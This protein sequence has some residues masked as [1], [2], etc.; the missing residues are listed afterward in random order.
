[1]KKS[2]GEGAKSNALTQVWSRNLGLQ[3]LDLF[4]QQGDVLQQIFVLQQQLM[5]P[6]LSLQTSR[7][8]GTQLVLQEVDLHRRMFKGSF[9]LTS[10]DIMTVFLTN[11]FFF[12][13]QTDFPKPCFSGSCHESDVCCLLCTRGVLFNL[14]LVYVQN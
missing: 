7:G 3:L 5:N 14:S 8:L 9:N 1:M 12:L 4:N 10:C 6:S 13:T 2:D 11:F